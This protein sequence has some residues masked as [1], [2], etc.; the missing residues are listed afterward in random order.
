[1]TGFA[2][3]A[4][5]LS[6]FEPG[7]L[8]FTILLQSGI[9]HDL[10]KKFEDDE[11]SQLKDTL[12]NILAHIFTRKFVPVFSYGDNVDETSLSNEVFFYH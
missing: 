6:N 7:N 8:I 12:V 2:F 11:K 4:A 5:H 9:L 1:M 10:L 3:L